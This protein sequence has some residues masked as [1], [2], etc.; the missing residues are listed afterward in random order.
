LAWLCADG[1]HDLNC[2]HVGGE[3]LA[4]ETGIELAV[5]LRCTFLR[6]FDTTRQEP[7]AMRAAMQPSIEPCARGQRKQGF[8]FEEAVG[9]NNTG[10][11]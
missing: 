6:K 7:P 9:G 10:T 3:I 4:L 2:I 11:L 8:Q 1:P 5:I